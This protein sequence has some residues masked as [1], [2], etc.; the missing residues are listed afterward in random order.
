MI[1]P[2]G[3]PLENFD[4]IGRYRSQEGGRAIDASGTYLTRD[5]DTVTF[6]GARDLARFLADSGET[7]DAF[8]EQLF[9]F[10]VKQPIRAYGVDVPEQLRRSFG[11]SGYNMRK[12]I[13][14]IVSQS[15]MPAHDRSS[16][17][18]SDPPS[19]DQPH[20]LP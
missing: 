12:L 2:L 4:A 11:S 8:V 20:P 13:V 10:L 5:G 1:N 9:H 15:S 3:F 17:E 7:H 19:T 6:T 16:S 14:E 18:S